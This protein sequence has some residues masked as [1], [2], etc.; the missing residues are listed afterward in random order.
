MT[1]TKEAKTTRFHELHVSGCFVIAN[2]WDVGPARVLEAAGFSGLGTTSAGFAWT[3]G[4][5]DGAMSVDLLLA[6]A[7]TIA[8]AVDVPVSGN[9]LKGFG[10]SPEAVAETIRLAGEAGLAG[11]SIED[12]TGDPTAPVFDRG[13]AKERIVAAVEAARNLGRSFILCART[14]D[15]CRCRKGCWSHPNADQRFGRYWQRRNGA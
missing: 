15:A 4:Q 1:V 14:H 10:A 9:S 11:G 7:K 3:V 13:L 12:T 8:E 2:A 6:N 5:K